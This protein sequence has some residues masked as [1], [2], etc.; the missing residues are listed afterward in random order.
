MPPVQHLSY[1]VA[2]LL[3]LLQGLTEFL[4]VSSTAH[5]EIVP[6]LFGMRDVG[7]AFSAIVQLGPMVAIIAYFRSD[8]VRYIEGILRSKSPAKV[9]PADID[10]RLGW[11]TLL[12]TIPLL[13][14]GFLLQKKVE[15][16]F[17]E[18][19]VTAFSLIILAVL[20]LAAEIVGRRR[21][22]LEQMS[23]KESQIIGWAQVLALIP[24]ASRSGVT[25]TAG[26]FQGLQREAAARFS[27]LLSIPAIT[28]AGLFESYKV[29]KHY[30]LGGETGPYLAGAVAAGLFAY[31]VV[32]WFLGFMKEHNT[33][34]FIIYRVL[35]GV[36]I[37]ILLHTGYIKSVPPGSDVP[38]AAPGTVAGQ[39]LIVNP[40][41]HFVPASPN[42]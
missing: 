27:F 37:L 28:A 42:Q 19:S 31:V 13:I 18:L 41:G 38:A 3:G 20:L 35:L 26:L 22:P 40:D 17:R 6:Q 4:P 9:A 24:G 10:A 1:P 25:I 36:A 21:K 11:F 5:M 33:T 32:K 34:I 23:F 7:A 15:H 39:Q 12:G 16:E 8:L 29:L 14:F 30:H 2:I